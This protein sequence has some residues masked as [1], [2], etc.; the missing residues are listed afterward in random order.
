MRSKID[1]TFNKKLA[2]VFTTSFLNDYLTNSYQD[3]LKEILNET[4]LIHR[5]P[6]YATVEQTLEL[7]YKYLSQNYRFEYVYKN[8]V[9]NQLLLKKHSLKKAILFSEFRAGISQLDLLIVNGTTTAYE[10]KTE[11]DSLSRLPV[12]LNSYTEMFD[13]T[14]VV[15]HEA[16]AVKVERLLP[17]SA[18]LMVLNQNNRLFT[19]KEARSNV[20]QLNHAA[21]FSSLRKA[22][23]CSLIREKF[24]KV[25]NMPNTKIYDYCLNLFKQLPNI[26]AHE[27]FVKVLRKRKLKDEQLDLVKSV[28]AA[29]KMLCLGKH[30]TG[31]ECTQLHN[32]FNSKPFPPY[33]HALSQR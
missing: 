5:L 31:A 11:L 7:I 13:K 22:E 18:G 6:T 25:P 14:F 17:E 1:P 8:T 15:T 32:T 3:K 12:Q 30:F 16:F 24:D 20:G 2:T 33:V 9:A 4:G 10:I 28:G 19:L 23:Y 27:S 21:M 26:E 29:L